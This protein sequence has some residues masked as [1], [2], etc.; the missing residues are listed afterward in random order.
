MLLSRLHSAHAHSFRGAAAHQFVHCVQT[1]SAQHDL[2]VCACA[3]AWQARRVADINQ[4][5]T[6]QAAMRPLGCAMMLIGMDVERGPQLFK[7]DPAGFYFG[8]RVRVLR[9]LH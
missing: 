2:H 9:W 4:L 7:C 1:V 8:Y 3:C 6:Q 5:Y